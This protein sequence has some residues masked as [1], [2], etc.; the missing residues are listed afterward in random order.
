[1]C[2]LDFGGQ[3]DDQL[4]LVEFAYNNSY[5]SSIRKARCEEL[6]GR[7][8]FSR[9]KS[10]ADPRWKDVEFVVDDYVF[11]KV[12]PIKGVMRFGKKGK[13]ASRYIRPF[14]ITDRMR[15]VAYRLELLP[16]FSH[17]H[18]VF[19]ISILRKYVPN[20][21]H[22]LQ[23]DTVELNENLT[24]KEQLATVVDYQM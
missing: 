10:Y 9:Q 20:P 3:W 5:H 22:V 17:V 19:H 13:L 24:F 15:A 6:Y 21:S 16:N 4:P 23:P 8:S 12:S 14:E 7:K 18:L 2:V 1:M 11:L